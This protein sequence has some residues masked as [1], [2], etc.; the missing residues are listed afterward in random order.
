MKPYI[1]NNDITAKTVRL[2]TESSSEVMAIKDALEYAYKNGL[3]LIQVNTTDV[4]VVKMVDLN[5]YLYEQKQSE[6]EALR[7][8]RQNVIQVKEVKF[9]F[10][11]QENDLNVK[12]K[13]AIKFLSESKHVR[14][15]MKVVGRISSGSDMYKQNIEAMKSFVQ[16]LGDIDFVQNVELQGKY[17]SCT[18]KSK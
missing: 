6:K 4:P 11:T 10:G 16:R 2:V 12:A 1:A 14:I 7:K 15:T 5:K 18:V 9:T 8:Q 13:S 3:D 17:V